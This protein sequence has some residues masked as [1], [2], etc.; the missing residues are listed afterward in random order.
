MPSRWLT[1]TA[2]SLIFET[3][4]LDGRPFQQRRV[5]TMSTSPS[6]YE[7]LVRGQMLL[8][9]GI[10]PQA[11]EDFNEALR[12]N[13]GFAPRLLL[14]GHGLPQRR[15]PPTGYSGLH[16]RRGGGAGLSPWPTT[17]GR[18]CIAT[19][20]TMNGLSPITTSPFSW[21]PR[22]QTSTTP[23]AWPTHRCGITLTP[24]PISSGHWNLTRKCPMP[25]TIWG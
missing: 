25:S 1:T 3:K 2:L 15:R 20:E 4:P 8:Q 5:A 16:Q 23:G 18:W 19:W 17:P 14:S 13:Q 6:E 9:Q 22:M 24:S 11:I 7:Y 21:N 12:L 10:L